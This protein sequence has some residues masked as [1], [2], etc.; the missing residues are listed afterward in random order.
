M[1]QARKSPLGLGE[2]APWFRCATLEGNDQYAFDSAGGRAILML[3]FGTAANAAAA[4]DPT[5]P[6][7]VIMEL[8]MRRPT[9]RR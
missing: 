9:G 5:N 2:A 4:R 1:P 3:F 7:R 6:R 8:K